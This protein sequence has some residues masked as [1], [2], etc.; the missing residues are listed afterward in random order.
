MLHT[1]VCVCECEFECKGMCVVHQGNNK[2]NKASQK[3]QQS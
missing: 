3:Q 1:N 2:N